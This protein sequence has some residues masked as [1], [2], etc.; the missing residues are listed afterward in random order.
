MKVFLSFLFVLT[1][2]LAAP[3]YSQVTIHIPG[4]YPTIQAGI[5]AANNG[6]VVLV[7]EGIYY[8]NI[9]F[10]G[11]AITVASTFTLDENVAHIE[12]TVINGSQHINP[13]SGSVVMFKS[14]EDTT[15]VL[16]GF[17][18]TGGTGTAATNL[19]AG[20]GIVVFYSGA[21]IKN[22]IIELN[23]LDNVL[24]AY[25]GGIYS[26]NSNI[27]VK[28]NIIR[29]NTCNG[30]DYAVGGGIKLDDGF[31]SNNKI[32]EN[33]VT[34]GINGTGGGIDVWGPINEV[35]II[36]NLIKGNT[37]QS[38]TGGGGG[39]D[40]Y[41]CT[42]N[43]PVIENNVIVDNYSSIF[44]GGVF[45]DLDID[46]SFKSGLIESQNTT[47]YGDALADQFLVNN[48]IYNNSA[49][50]SGGGICTY[51]MTSNIMNCIL[52]G[53]TAPADP[54]ITGA[55]NVEYSD[56]EGGWTGTGNI[57]EHPLFIMDSE[58][59]HLWET[60][61]CV[62]SGN[63]GPQYNDVE[64]PYNLGYA[65][66]PAW[67]TLRND[68]GHAGGPASLWCYWEWPIPVELTSFTATIQFGKV[69][70]NWTTATE[71]NNLGFDIERKILNNQNLGE[72][73]K[74]GFTEGYGTTTEPKEYSYSDDVSTIQA[75]S[76]AYR[77][78]QIDYDGSYE[79]SDEVSVVN[80]APVDYALQQN[81]PNP[82]N[83]ATTISYSLPI[84]S[85]VELVVYNALGESVMRL[86]NEEKEAGSYK[87]EFSAAGLPSGVYFYKLDAGNYKQVKKMILMK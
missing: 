23:T 69:N 9:D 64:D 15:S 25:G 13:D 12:N 42:T 60:S 6:D 66:E 29:N 57:N 49:G 8:E 20:G 65:M 77:L 46:D 62:D 81:Y 51:D 19:R 70:L 40:I 17:T 32:L 27:V 59:Y 45:V 47:E 16:C 71:T 85:Q 44:G 14:G 37:M 61:P 55:V 43:T 24:W 79:F 2:L 1:F 41:E 74:I 82:F 73:K 35:N 75:S 48:T 87:I 80:T 63:P 18:I 76:F 30:T 28:N 26:Q 83:P 31:I 21:Q 67:G 7:D 4:D 11:K 38:P 58:F 72:W 54:Q 34:A 78:K 39:I 36:S 50:V 3:N 53:N 5:N 84:K 22:N 86:V 33:T 68:I 52:W 56:V 10:V